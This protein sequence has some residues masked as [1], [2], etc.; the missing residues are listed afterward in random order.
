VYHAVRPDDA[1]L[2]EVG[3]G[4]N[5]VSSNGSNSFTSGAGNQYYL[6]KSDSAAVARAIEQQLDT[7]SPPPDTTAPA[8][9]GVGA[10]GST[11]AWSTDEP[12]TS[13]VEYGTSTAYG[14]STTLDT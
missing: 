3:P 1:I 13:Q 8:I 4:K 12:A 7:L 10:S 5:T 2:R 6:V 9:T 11:V 14:S